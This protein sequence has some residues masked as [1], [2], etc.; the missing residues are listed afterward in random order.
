ML[1]LEKLHNQQLPQQG[2]VKQYYTGLNDVLRIFISRKMKVIT[3][4]K[5]SEE[6]IMQ[7]KQLGVPH[8]SLIQLAQTLR[9]SDAVKFAKFNPENEDNE[10]SYRHVKTT[11]ELINELNK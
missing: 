6:L 9:M 10:L 8:E 1:S 11:V 2:L 5:T 3:M 7:V 4:Q